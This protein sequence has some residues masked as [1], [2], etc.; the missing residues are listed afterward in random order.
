MALRAGS[1][2][3]LLGGLDGPRLARMHVRAFLAGIISAGIGWGVVHLFGPLYDLSWVRAVL[4]CVLVGPLMTGIYFACLRAMH[5][6][7]AATLTGS[8]TRLLRRRR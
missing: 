4:I 5:V 2:S 8:V 6:Q 7:E 1:L 3:R